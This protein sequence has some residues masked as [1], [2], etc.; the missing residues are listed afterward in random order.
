MFELALPWALIFL[1]LPL[2]IWYFLPRAHVYLP[3]ALRVP[4]FD[5]LLATVGDRKGRLSAETPKS[6][7]LLIWCLL[8]F[9][10][11]GPRWVGDP[12]PL[13]REGRN[14]MLV[15][16]LS[17]SMEL[18][19]M[20]LHNRPVSR[21]TVVKDTAEQF[22]RERVG[23]RIGLILFGT[24]A[25]LQ[26]PLT[27]DRQSVLLRL[28]DAT[29]GLAG[30]TTSI[31]D[32]LGLA[33]KRLQNVPAKGRVIILLT[34]GANN[35]GVLPPLKAAELA[36]EDNIKVYTIGLGSEGDPRALNNMFFN[37]NVSS[38]LDEET[39]QEIAKIT[40]GRY[41]RATDTQSLSA[42]YQTINQLETITQE[43]ATIRPQHDYY[44]WP[45]GL[46]F[47]LFCFWMVY[48]AGLFSW[49]QKASRREVSVHD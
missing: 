46:A 4:F 9:A 5:D 22:V 27:Y 2:L 36:K 41:F 37:M 28:E 35:S 26:T 42:I 7:L 31:G 24:R 25:Y 16:D 20:T 1:P 18:P 32:A 15:L 38:D 23:D 3:A 12:L 39:L 34:D 29:V 40:G 8:L 14:I 45:L 43:Q 6:V 11:A 13:T 49:I 10:V 30:Q 48:G 19:D 47:L 21:L 44:L 33:V 17:G